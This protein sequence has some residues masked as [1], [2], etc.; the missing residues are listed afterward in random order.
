MPSCRRRP[1]VP[2]RRAVCGGQAACPDGGARQSKRR[3]RGNSGIDAGQR[4]HRGAK[5][6]KICK[7]EKPLVS[8]T[9]IPGYAHKHLLVVNDG[10]TQQVAVDAVGCGPVDW[11]SCV[12]SSAAREAAGSKEYPS[13]LTIVGIIDYW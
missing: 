5:A 2:L 9:R 4:V 13:V 7:V 8:T 1:A 12:V 11:V 6:M 10:K 3:R